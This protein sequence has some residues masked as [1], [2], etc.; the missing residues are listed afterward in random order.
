VNLKPLTWVAAA[1]AVA[2][3]LALTACA[4]APGRTVYAAAATPPASPASA[5]APPAPSPVSTEATVTGQCTPGLLDDS[6]RQFVPLDANFHGASFSPGDTAAEAYQMALTN[7]GTTAA[8]VTGFSAV[9]YTGGTTETTSDTETFGS[10]T[11][12]EPGQALT[13][14]ETPWGTYTISESA[15]QP[16]QPIGPFTEGVSGAVD[17]SATCQLVQWTHP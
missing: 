9:F 13:W 15:G 2:A 14:T 11:F 3:T 16:S 1:V 4:A 17:A 8:E 12:L 6:T 7:T 10:P 5:T